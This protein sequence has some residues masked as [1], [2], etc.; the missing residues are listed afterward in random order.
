MNLVGRKQDVCFPIVKM[1]TFKTPKCVPK[2]KNLAKLLV[3]V[4]LGAFT[5]A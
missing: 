1:G 5:N 2:A 4:G 3:R